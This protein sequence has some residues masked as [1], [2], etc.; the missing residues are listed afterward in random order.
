MIDPRPRPPLSQ[1]YKVDREQVE[2]EDE[3]IYRRT[4]WLLTTQSILFAA[5]TVAIV[6]TYSGLLSGPPP[7]DFLDVKPWDTARHDTIRFLL[8]FT[9][10]LGLM[11]ALINFVATVA[12][13]EAIVAICEHYDQNRIY[14]IRFRRS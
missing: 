2:R 3:L 9:P 7:Y 4:Y 11:V 6:S 1:L 8:W 10:V 13:L 14:M 12:A 5:Y